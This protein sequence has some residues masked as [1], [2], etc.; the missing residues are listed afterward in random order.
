MSVCVQTQV[1]QRSRLDGSG[2]EAVIRTELH[3]PDGVAIDWIARNVHWTDTG[4]NRI[5]VAR[6]DG[7]ARKV[8]HGAGSQT[9]GL[10]AW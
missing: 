10:M 4:S 9:A 3:S 7:F 2:Q 1:I 5:E 6:L 8:G